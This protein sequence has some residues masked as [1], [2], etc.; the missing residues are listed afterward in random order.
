LNDLMIT[1]IFEEVNILSEAF[2]YSVKIKSNSNNRGITVEYI[3][4]KYL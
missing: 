2:E 1:M 4:N 3:I